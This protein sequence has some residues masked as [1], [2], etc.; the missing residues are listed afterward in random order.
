M[1]ALI[2]NQ[3]QQ[4]GPETMVTSWVADCLNCVVRTE[5][6]IDVR[7]VPC[8]RRLGE[9]GGDDYLLKKSVDKANVYYKEFLKMG[10]AKKNIC[11][12]D[13]HADSAVGEGWGSL[14]LYTSKPGE[15]LALFVYRELEKIT[16]WSD[17]GTEKRDNLWTLNKS[18]AVNTVVECS[19]YDETR[20]KVWMQNN[21]KLIALAIL[22][23]VYM[24]L[25]V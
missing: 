9:S 5:D 18:L 19:F 2:I 21:A 11:Q 23:G 25:G 13:I 24:Y 1:K 16:P 6:K 17:R 22:K 4:A 10:I 3:S 15:T 12:V 7:L 8:Y 20:Q 14:C